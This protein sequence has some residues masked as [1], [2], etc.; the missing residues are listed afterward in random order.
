MKAQYALFILVLAMASPVRAKYFVSLT[1]ARYRIDY[2]NVRIGDSSHDVHGDIELVGLGAGLT[3]LSP[4]FGYE[5]QLQLLGTNSQKLT[6]EPDW[7]TTWYYRVI[8]KGNY[9]LP[10][11]GFVFI[12]GDLMGTFLQSTESHYFGPGGFTGLGYRFNERFTASISNPNSSILFSGNS[13]R[14]M[15]GIVIEGT[16]GF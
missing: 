8:G 11:G 12:G 16:Y 3:T 13:E 7:G 5:A 2:G 14:V 10:F 9:M 1:G 15:R 4:G 6:P